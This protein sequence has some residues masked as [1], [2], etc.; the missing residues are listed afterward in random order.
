M[1]YTR[2]DALIDVM[3]TAA[4]D[5]ESTVDSEKQPDNQAEDARSSWEFTDPTLM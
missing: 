1:E 2:L 5:V 4:K 3:F